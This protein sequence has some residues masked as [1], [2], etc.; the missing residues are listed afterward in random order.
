VRCAW[1]LN[2]SVNQNMFTHAC[3]SV[4]HRLHVF[5]SFSIVRASVPVVSFIRSVRLEGGW[6]WGQ[7]QR[8]TFIHV[9]VTPCNTHMQSLSSFLSV[10]SFDWHRDGIYST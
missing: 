3:H 1:N 6:G 9:H 8:Y 4:S 10:V 5:L 7:V 2:V